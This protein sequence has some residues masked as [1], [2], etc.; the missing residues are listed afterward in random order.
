MSC[1]RFGGKPYISDHPVGL[2]VPFSSP[3]FGMVH[4]VLQ[5]RELCTG[6]CYISK[7]MCHTDSVNNL[8]LTWPSHR[9]GSYKFDLKNI[10][11]IFPGSRNI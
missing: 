5:I 8:W 11:A 4:E 1:I 2:H 7:T 6:P 9:T 10:Q 3:L